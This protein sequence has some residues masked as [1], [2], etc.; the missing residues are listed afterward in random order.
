M[1]KITSSNFLCCNLSK[2]PCSSRHGYTGNRKTSKNVYAG[3]WWP[4]RT[5]SVKRTEQCNRVNRFVTRRSFLSF[6]HPHRTIFIYLW[7]EQ[8][9]VKSPLSTYW[10][11][12]RNTDR[13]WN[14]QKVSVVRVCSSYKMPNA[15]THHTVKFEIFDCNQR[16]FWHLVVKDET[17]GATQPL[18]LKGLWNRNGENY[19]WLRANSNTKRQ[20]RNL[21]VR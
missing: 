13:T 9:L 7:L 10:H 3:F 14:A 2:W 4:L 15:A 20:L 21:N 12:P 8:N 16:K 5:F 18:C 17:G 11:K 6:K 19:F 1:D